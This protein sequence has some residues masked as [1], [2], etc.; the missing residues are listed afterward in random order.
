MIF[1]SIGKYPRAILNNLCMFCTNG[2]YNKKETPKINP[3][4]Y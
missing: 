1:S 2:P 4:I 3:V